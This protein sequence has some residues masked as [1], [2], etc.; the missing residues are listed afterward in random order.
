ME[1]IINTIVSGVREMCRCDF[2]TENILERTFKCF[3]NSENQVSFRALLKETNN[4]SSHTLI[5]HLESFVNQSH[6]WIV[7]GQALQL[8]HTCNVM[9][10]DLNAPECNVVLLTDGGSSHTHFIWAVI[11]TSLLAVSVIILAILSVVI[12][13]IKQNQRSRSIG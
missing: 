12:V 10:S 9:I 5:T 6:F 13:L 11:S 2:T 8:N 1:D 3:Q 4:T 7:H